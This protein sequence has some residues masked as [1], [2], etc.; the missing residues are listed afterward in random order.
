[1]SVV[2]A[3][4]RATE[5][6]ALLCFPVPEYVKEQEAEGQKNALDLELENQELGPALKP[7]EASVCRL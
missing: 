5:S 1:M 6:A 2:S 4:G 3:H 7:S